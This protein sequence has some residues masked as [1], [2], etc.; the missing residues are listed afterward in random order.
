MN[1]GSL[2]YCAADLVVAGNLQVSGSISHGGSAIPPSGI[3]TISQG[4]ATYIVSPDINGNV[5]FATQPTGG[6]KL[7]TTPAQVAF[8]VTDKVMYGLSVGATSVVAQSH[9]ITLTSN[10]QS[11]AITPGAAGSSSINF[12]VASGAIKQLTAGGQ[13]VNPS[14]TGVVSLSSPDNSITFG[15]SSAATLQLSAAPT[16]RPWNHLTGSIQTP[17]VGYGVTPTS[18]VQTLSCIVSVS[19]Y[20][21]SPG[22]L[23]SAFAIILDPAVFTPALLAPYRVMATANWITTTGGF[24]SFLPSFSSFLA[25]NGE[26]TG[27]SRAA[28]TSGYTPQP[29]AARVFVNIYLCPFA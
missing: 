16:L 2:S 12:S 21:V 4:P 29:G 3:A 24:G 9:N 14:S 15:S 1:S 7:T 10:D 5:V 22:V 28:N 25:G 20:Y 17:V 23:E 18:K 27:V 6:V 19:E 13:T 11:L 26:I 8:D